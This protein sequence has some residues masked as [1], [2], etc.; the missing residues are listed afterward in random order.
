VHP[1]LD[2][3]Q[4][5]NPYDVD[6]VNGASIGGHPEAHR[7]WA[8]D[9]GNG[10]VDVTASTS[11]VWNSDNYRQVISHGSRRTAGP[12]RSIYLD[13][14]TLERQKEFWHEIQLIKSAN[15]SQNSHG[16]LRSKPCNDRDARSMKVNKRHRLH[17]QTPKNCVIAPSSRQTP[18]QTSG[19]EGLVEEWENTPR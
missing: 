1:S 15:R 18:L 13:S 8:K 5:W 14:A 3:L 6:P 9:P 10:T 4:W 7:I 16:E 11:L 2:F 12:G 19:L 17:S